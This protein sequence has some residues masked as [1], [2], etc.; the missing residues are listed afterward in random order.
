M[1]L[2]TDWERNRDRQYRENA[3]GR[4]RCK[5]DG[6]LLDLKTGKCWAC[7]TVN[8]AVAKAAREQKGA[9]RV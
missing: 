8:R 7:G 4:P 6:Y 5:H 1:N 9:L 3:K 2:K